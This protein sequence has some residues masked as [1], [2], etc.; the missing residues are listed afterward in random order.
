MYDGNE[1]PRELGDDTNGFGGCEN[2]IQSRMN[3]F[4]LLDKEKSKF[5]GMRRR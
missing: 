1:W 5:F 4:E 2:V 3:Q